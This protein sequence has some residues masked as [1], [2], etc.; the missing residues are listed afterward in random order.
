MVSSL[1][2]PHPPPNPQGCPL[3]YIIKNILIISYYLSLVLLLEAKP[4]SE[5]FKLLQKE[6]FTKDCKNCKD[7]KNTFTRQF[8]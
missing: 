3:G 7:H 5:M 8:L 4:K 1:Q 6:T 2:Y